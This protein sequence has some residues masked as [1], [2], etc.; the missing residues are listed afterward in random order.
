MRE[1]R[2]RKI[3]LIWKTRLKIKAYID[4]VK[5]EGLIGRLTQRKRLYEANMR[6]F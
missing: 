2:L 3:E 4:N 5:K 1:R 6:R